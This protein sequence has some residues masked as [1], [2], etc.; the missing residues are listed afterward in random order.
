MTVNGVAELGNGGTFGVVNPASGQVFAEAPNCD[1]AT[2]EFAISAANDAFPAWARHPGRPELLLEC[3][4]RLKGQT[5]KLAKLLTQEQGKPLRESMNEVMGAAVALRYAAEMAAPAERELIENSGGPSIE[6][7]RRPLGV[8][9]AITPWNFPVILAIWKI[10]PAL[11]AGNTVVL[12]PSPFTP[13]STLVFCELFRDVLPPGVLNV[14]SGDD[15]IGKALTRHPAIRKITLTGSV[16]TGKAVARSAADDLKRVV[17]ELGGNDAA[18]VLPDAD[19]A[20]I[21]EDL[22]WGAFRNCGQVCLAIKRLYV[23]EAIFSAVVDELKRIAEGVKVGD[24]LEKG[25]ELGPLNNQPQLERVESLVN[26]AR[27]RGARI[28]TGGRR[29]PG[30]GFF[31]EPTIVTEIQEGAPL[32]DEEQFGPALP[33]LRFD[34]VD[35]AISRANASSFGLGGSVWSADPGRALEIATRLECGTA[36]V[37]QHGTTNPA[38]PVGGKKWSGIG[39]ENGQAGLSEYLDLQTVYSAPKAST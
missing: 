21:A 6:I 8:V 23:H 3:A 33:V 20:K 37:N 27:E 30:S 34:D 14:V 29:R 16:S 7:R 4:K 35:D 38:A 25:I 5:V 12:K 18:I 39:Y 1:E 19:P 28:V 24:G 17:L 32:V 36:W 11:R 22:F 15:E 31:F 26:D 10:A 13:L 2:L 9:A